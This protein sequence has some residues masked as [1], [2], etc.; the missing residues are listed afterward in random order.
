MSKRWIEPEPIVIPDSLQAYYDISPYLAEVLAKKGITDAANTVPFLDY[1]KYT[2][3]DPSELPGV[4]KATERI[5]LAI[6]EKK[7]VGIWGDFDV[8]GQTSTALLVSFF[9][10]LDVPVQYHIP[11]RSEESH[12]ILN[13]PLQD[14]L[15]GGVELL[16]TCDT[17]ISAN[18]VLNAATHAGVD[19]ILTDHHT[20]P[21][22]L[23]DVFSIINPHFVHAGHAYSALSGV[24]TAYILTRQLAA[25]LDMLESWEKTALDLVAMG[26]IADVAPLVKENRYM[27]QYGLELMRTNT[28]LGIKELLTTARTTVERLDEQDVS[29][30]IAPRLNALGRLGNANPIV[31]FLLTNDLALARRMATELEGLNNQRKMLVNQVYQAAA[32]QI[33]QDSG[34][35][36]RNIIILSN[37]AWPAGIL[38]IVANHLTDFY[39]KPAILLTADSSG[40][41]KGSA[42]SIQGINIT[43][44]LKANGELLLS[45]GG[46]AMAAGLALRRENLER[47]KQNMHT[48]IASI[49]DV[50][51][52]EATL[53]IDAYLPLENVTEPFMQVLDRLAPFGAGNPSPI[54]LA[55]HLHIANARYLDRD[56]IH[57]SIQVATADGQSYEVKWWHAFDTLLPSDEISLA[58]SIR[59]SVFRGETRI[60]IEWVDAHNT[61]PENLPALVSKPQVAIHDFR[62]SKVPMDDFHS[63]IHTFQPVCWGEN[64]AEINESVYN[65][66]EIP[67]HAVLA[68]LHMPPGGTVL[69]QIFKQ[70]HPSTIGFFNLPQKPINVKS[71]FQIMLGMLKYAMREKEGQVSLNH[72]AALTGYTMEIIELGLSF[73]EADGQITVQ[74]GKDNERVIAKGHQAIDAIMRAKYQE[75]MVNAFKSMQAF[76]RFLLRLPPERIVADY[77][78]R[79]K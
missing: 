14:F 56:K 48:S 59:R 49:A 70:V 38:G 62:F 76:Q 15:A 50:Q 51:R 13:E 29:F 3:T 4:D 45:F 12:G 19:V 31:E 64:L 18:K 36:K 72:Y 78:E 6:H 7:C 41:L 1:L 27:V 20:P 39:G 73:L 47:F 75:K 10:S 57:R 35:E 11:I 26:T 22:V 67:E 16:I 28:R 34:F 9:R 68:F 30:I 60:E 63:F 43:D 53:A 44:L 46:H 69:Q 33:E 8:D 54:F 52:L 23:P 77:Y 66:L 42:R 17:G 5:L 24:G 32:A 79:G 61:L 71:F 37:P 74:P 40:N 65:R 2:P 25:K 21:Q 58:Y 55:E